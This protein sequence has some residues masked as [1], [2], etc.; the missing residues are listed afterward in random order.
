MASLASDALL[1]VL[2]SNFSYSLDDQHVLSNVNKKVMNVID[3]CW[4]T[5]S[6]WATNH[7]ALANCSVGFGKAAVGGKHGAIYVVTNSYDDDPV[8]LN[9]GTL[10]YGVVQSSPLWIIFD[11][12]MVIDRAQKS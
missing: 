5:K 7:K 6:N 1:L 11:K 12:D 2:L 3:S 10:R 9:P 4:R 8:S